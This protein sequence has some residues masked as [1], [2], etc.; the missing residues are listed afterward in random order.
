[1]MRRALNPF[2]LAL[3]V[4]SSAAARQDTPPST[5][6]PPPPP[7]N[8]N[9]VPA[10]PGADPANPSAQP[11]IVPPGTSSAEGAAAAAPN[12]A[13]DPKAMAI[14]QRAIDAAKALTSFDGVISVKFEGGDTED[15]AMLTA[16]QIPRRVRL[17]LSADGGSG[18]K[19]LRIDSPAGP[20]STKTLTF[21]GTRSLLVNHTD[22]TCTTAEGDGS[23]FGIAQDMAMSV[24]GFLFKLRS[25]EFR[26]EVDAATVAAAVEGKQSIGKVDC[27]VIS[28][29]R[30]IKMPSDD[31]AAP[32]GSM[33]TMRQS[34]TLLVGIADGIVRSEKIRIE[35]SGRD[36]R[37]PMPEFTATDV[38][39]N[40]TF[41]PDDFSTKPPE[42]YKVI[43]APPGPDS[44]ASG[45]PPL[46]F[47]VGDAAPAFDLK[48]LAGD[49][50]TLKSLAGKVVLLDFWA[51]WCGPCR[52][53]MPVLQNLSVEFKDKPVAVY[54][55]NMGER[56]LDAGR[57]YMTKKGYTYGCLLDG[58]KLAETYK[59]TGIP[60]L[61]VIGKDG[62]IVKTSVGGDNDAGAS[63][64]EAINAALAK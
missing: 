42:G 27:D 55:V 25:D 28:L 33:I 20:G 48:D 2:V 53:V 30:E 22:K 10:V 19:R 14:Y 9:P 54:G 60:T 58:D 35:I 39:V 16:M 21:D 26:S 44:F 63:L 11:V 52:Q 64:R 37:M 8:V 43:E 36:E 12:A 59:V 4:A 49:H 13:I 61:I 23:Y 31:E 18:L 24:P 47:K 38:L 6:T 5:P 56:K 45:P 40:P 51:T 57:E 46:A 1:M 32:E 29:V 17:E 7:I 41:G 62:V 34:E 3:L 15:N 50:I